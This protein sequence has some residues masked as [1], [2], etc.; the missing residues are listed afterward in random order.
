MAD[1]LDLPCAQALMFRCN[2]MGTNGSN[3]PSEDLPDFYSFRFR[4]RDR[5]SI[6][7]SSRKRIELIIIDLV[8]SQ[9]P[10]L[11]V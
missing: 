1:Y 7:L 3:L 9:F 5:G 8:M 6:I 2:V 4:F 11:A 10:G